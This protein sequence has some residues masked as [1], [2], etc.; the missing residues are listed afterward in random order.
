VENPYPYVKNSIATV[1]TSLSEGFSLALVESVLLN[2]P[3]ISTD[4][5]VAREL[6]TNFNCGNIVSYDAK[7][8]ADVMAG[9]LKKYDG[10]PKIFDIG[11]SYDIETEVE[12]TEALI[13]KTIQKKLQSCQIK[14]LPYPEVTITIEELENYTIEKDLMYVLRVMKDRVPYEYL[15]HVRNDTDKLIVFH[16]G[17][18]AD[19]NVKS[20]V[21]Q[22]HSWAKQL[23]TSS[24]FCM[25]PT[26]YVN[27]SLQVGWGIGQN[28][29]YYLENSSLIL[30]EIIEKAGISLGNTAVYGSSAGGYLSILTGIYL[31]GSKVV[32]DNAQFDVRNW[33]YKD[34]LNNV[35]LLCFDNVCDA[36]QYK[37]RF[38]VAE[39]F[40]KHGYVPKIYAHVNLASEADNSTQL[41]PFLKEAEKLKSIQDY[42]EIEVILHYAPEKGHD[43]MGMEEAVN[44]L[45]GILEV[46]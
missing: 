20:P 34:A 26:L 22:R 6:V 36:L 25:D 44:F 33:I 27:S 39:A 35:I 5:G 29:N 37:E 13:E 24:I 19:G 21:F 45:Y 31:K 38:S 7:E 4:V 8:L 14:E 28:E 41:V 42:H 15:L 30:K 12:K 16:N 40:E 43:G 23:K 9:Y 1:L 17:A 3:I 46:S 32:A 2:T 11:S 10:Y 18:V